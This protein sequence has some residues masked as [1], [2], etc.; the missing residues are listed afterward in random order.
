MLILRL[1][2]QLGTSEDGAHTDIPQIVRNQHSEGLPQ[3]C[4]LKVTFWIYLAEE[5]V[6]G[7]VFFHLEQIFQVA[8]V[9]V[10]LVAFLELSHGLV[11]DGHQRGGTFQ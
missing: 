10:L 9:N 11:V 3:Y 2:V 4:Y 7:V 1:G 6:Q 5:L 8:S